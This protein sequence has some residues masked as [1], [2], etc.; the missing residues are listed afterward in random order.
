MHYMSYNVIFLALVEPSSLQF[1]S[2]LISSN[3]IGRIVSGNEEHF[4][5]EKRAFS[6]N[7]ML[8]YD[9]I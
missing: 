2:K 6:D 7:S 8:R 5:E 4:L 3:I 1:D 9:S